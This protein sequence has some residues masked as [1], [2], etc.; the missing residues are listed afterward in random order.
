M[1]L[2]LWLVLGGGAL[3]LAS[4]AAAPRDRSASPDLRTSD[5]DVDPVVLAALTTEKDPLYLTSLAAALRAGGRSYQA[6]KLEA[7]A[8]KLRA[9]GAGVA[10]GL[11][12]SASPSATIA[13]AAS[14][15]VRR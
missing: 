13:R 14:V 15:M 2:W 8:A 12:P 9:G 10:I 1:P 6:D 11:Q 7:R 3:L 4:G 5:P